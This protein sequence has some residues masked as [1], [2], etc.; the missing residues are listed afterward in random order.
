MR[1][2]AFLGAFV[3]AMIALRQVFRTYGEALGAPGAGAW[4]AA[5]GWTA[6]LVAAFLYAGFLLYAA[7]RAAGKLQR[8]IG[9]YERFLRRG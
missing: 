7:D 1:R 8:R 5:A 4:L 6:L 3:V 9:L 2:L